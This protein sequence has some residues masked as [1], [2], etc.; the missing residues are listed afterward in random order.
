VAISSGATA[1]VIISSGILTTIAVDVAGLRVSKTPRT[2]DIFEGLDAWR[3]SL[4]EEDT[5]ALVDSSAGKSVRWVSGRGLGVGGRV[6]LGGGAVAVVEL[7][8]T[9]GHER[10]ACGLASW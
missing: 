3:R 1:P 4:P 2:H 6:K 9:F 8:P 7:D 5:E 10:H